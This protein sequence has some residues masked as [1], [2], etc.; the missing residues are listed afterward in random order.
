[1]NQLSF[2]HKLTE[3]GGD[4]V[5]Y[6]LLFSSVVALTVI[7]ERALV[8]MRRHKEQG[9]TLDKLAR[10]PADATIDDVRRGLPKGSVL[11]RIAIDVQSHAGKGLPIVEAQLE[12]RLAL[13]RNELEKRLLILATLGNNA[14]F[15]GLLGTVLGV[16]RAFHDLGASAGQ[17][18]EVVMQGLA[19]ALIATAV[20]IIVALPCV[21]SYN[22][23]QKRVNDL[24]LEADRFGRT[25]IAMLAVE[26]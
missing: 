4:W 17:G 5:I 8:I 20:G 18:P 26:A 7:I 21:A 6:L 9:D 14:P 3:T 22:Y 16:I 15:V 23:L 13:E 19:E 1:M 11:E 2:L 10:Q 25:L 12:T 24:M